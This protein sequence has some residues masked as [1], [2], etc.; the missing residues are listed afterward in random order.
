MA[1]TV[2]FDAL[3]YFSSRKMGFGAFAGRWS[4]SGGR[5][6]GDLVLA[7]ED[8]LH[9]IVD[10][11]GVYDT[12]RPPVLKDLGEGKHHLM[13]W[14]VIDEESKTHLLGAREVGQALSANWDD[15]LHDLAKVSCD[16]IDVE[17][18]VR[19]SVPLHW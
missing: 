5:C 6:L 13:G 16:I 7:R 11:L 18:V 8:D 15:T 14:S 19:M 17:G 10:F 2:L 1:F 12:F 9:D 3:E 4:G